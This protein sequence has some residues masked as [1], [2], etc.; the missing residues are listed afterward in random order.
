MMEKTNQL[1]RRKRQKGRGYKYDTAFKLKIARLYFE[2]ADTV[3]GIARKFNIPHQ[4]VSRWAQ[5]FSCELAEE[6]II[7][8]MTEQEQKEVEALQK[9]IE[10]LKKK[11]EYDQIKIFALETMID[12]AKTELGIDVRKNYGAKQPKE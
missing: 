11:L 1:P 9:Q 3:Q 6:I 2:S 5:E 12:L 7:P 4:S 8:P 10:A